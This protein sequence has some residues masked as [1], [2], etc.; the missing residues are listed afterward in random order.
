MLGSKGK[1][2]FPRELSVMKKKLKLLPILN[3]SVS[4]R[5]NPEVYEEVPPTISLASNGNEEE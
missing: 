5:Y 2:S 4:N 1:V 3:P